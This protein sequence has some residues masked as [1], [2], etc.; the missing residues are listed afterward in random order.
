M[1]KFGFD[2]MFVLVQWFLKIWKGWINWQK[3]LPVC[4]WVFRF[5]YYD[6]AFRW[7][8]GECGRAKKKQ[9]P[10]NCLKASQ[11]VRHFGCRT[12]AFN[13]R[14]VT[15]RNDSTSSRDDHSFESYSICLVT[16]QQIIAMYIAHPDCP[17]KFCITFVFHFSWVLQP[18]Q[19]KMKTFDLTRLGSCGLATGWDWIAC[20]GGGRWFDF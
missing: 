13:L 5:S 8:F 18:S 14:N 11:L 15:D 3:F 12:C 17:P 20:P 7:Q 6:C 10:K 2:T 16:L 4:D 9:Q 1:R 19:E